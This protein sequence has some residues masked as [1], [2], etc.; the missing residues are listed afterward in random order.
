LDK[1]TLKRLLPTVAS[2]FSSRLGLSDEAE[3]TGINTVVH[4]Q[5]E[6]RRI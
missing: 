4:E 5:F 3:E 1:A 6:R 2:G